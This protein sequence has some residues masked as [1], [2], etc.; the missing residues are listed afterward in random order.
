MPATFSMEVKDGEHTLTEGIDYTLTFSTDGGANYYLWGDE[1][2]S[3][4]V[5]GYYVK[6]TGAG[7]SYTGTKE[8]LEYF[9][10]NEYQTLGGVTYHITEP[11]Y[12]QPAENG[13]VMIGAKT[14]TAIAVA[15]TTNDVQTQL[16]NKQTTIQIGNYDF[17]FNVTG[18]EKEAF[19][20]CTALTT[21]TLPETIT[22]IGDAAFSGCT[23][24]RWID[25][26]TAENYSPINFSRDTQLNLNQTNP[27]SGLPRQTLVYLYGPTY[28]VEN[29]V[30][31]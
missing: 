1:N 3:T 18:I 9:V 8:F 5:G 4:N 13:E 22:F 12:S 14:G 24:L 11:A 10:V 16:S 26:N 30:F 15:A 28:S 2:L 27:F 7:S 21:L 25:L 29:Y 17:T 31:T 20:E 6:V 19:K 23:G